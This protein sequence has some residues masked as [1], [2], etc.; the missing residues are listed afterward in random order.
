MYHIGHSS[1]M[2]VT[3]SVNGNYSQNSIA[4]NLTIFSILIHCLPI[5][6]PYLDLNKS[7][8]SIF[9]VTEFQIEFGLS[10]DIYFH[11]PYA[12]CCFLFLYAFAYIEWQIVEKNQVQ[13]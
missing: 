2:L 11:I 12:S 9:G 3:M 13:L 8:F 4:I 1:G 5:W 7:I 6:V 10:K